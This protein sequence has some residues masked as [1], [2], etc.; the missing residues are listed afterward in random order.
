MSAN[1]KKRLEQ[2]KTN[3]AKYFAE[4]SDVL[5]A[6]EFTA[7]QQAEILT[8]W[9]NDAIQLMRATEENMPADLENSN[10]NHLSAVEMALVELARRISE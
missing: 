9:K 7:A 5:E 10:R 8:Q 3:P 6:S 4:P 1:V 2:V